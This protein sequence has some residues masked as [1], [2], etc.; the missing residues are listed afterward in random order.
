MSVIGGGYPAWIAFGVIALIFLAL[1]IYTRRGLREQ[2]M[3]ETERENFKKQIE[4][5][6]RSEDAE[7]RRLEILKR[8]NETKE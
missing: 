1:F 6:E 4:A 8:R 7:K 3:R 2:A 5:M